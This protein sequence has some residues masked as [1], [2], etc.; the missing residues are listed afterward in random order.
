MH[1]GNSILEKIRTAKLIW[2][3]LATRVTYSFIL[4]IQFNLTIFFQFDCLFL[5]RKIYCTRLSY[6]CQFLFRSLSIVS[7][8]IF[9]LYILAKDFHAQVNETENERFFWGL[10]MVSHTLAMRI[11]SRAINLRRFKEIGTGV[12]YETMIQ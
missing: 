3:F 6:I 2:L 12:L 8:T 7:F 4:P 1:R 11:I 10:R 9:V 5:T